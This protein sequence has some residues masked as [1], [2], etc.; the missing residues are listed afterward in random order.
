MKLTENTTEILLNGLAQGHRVAYAMEI[1]PRLF[2]EYNKRHK[3]D[4][5]PWRT[6]RNGE[7]VERFRAS[8]LEIVTTDNTF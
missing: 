7:E 2:V 3:G 8:E 4:R 1:E 5:R 6:T